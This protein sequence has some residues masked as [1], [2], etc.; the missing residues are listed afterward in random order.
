VLVGADP[1]E[2]VWNIVART[3]EVVKELLG[4]GQPELVREGR[5][6]V[7]ILG[8]NPKAEVQKS[9]EFVLLDGLGQLVVIIRST[10][11]ISVR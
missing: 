1:L 6:F 4:L 2:A 11:K 8:L 3:V 7:R 5:V 10:N 9:L